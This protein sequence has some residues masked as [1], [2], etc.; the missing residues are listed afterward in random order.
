MT[1]YL[2]EL[3]SPKSA[4]LDLDVTQRHR[5]FEAIASGMEALAALGIEAVTLGKTDASIL[6]APKHQFFAIWRAPD[7]TS[8]NALISGIAATGWHDYFETINAAGEGGDFGGHLAQLVA[9]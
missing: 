6:Y 5:F 2:A 1:Y 3:Y 7:S 9:I 8:M 4:W